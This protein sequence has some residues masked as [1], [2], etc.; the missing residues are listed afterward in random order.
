MRK[1]VI[2]PGG[3]HPFHAGHMALYTAAREAFPSAEIYVAATADTSTRPFPFDVKKKLARLAGIPAHRF[4]QVKS[5]FRANEITE[6]FEPNDTV[7][8]FVR[9]EKD[10][11]QQPQSGGVKKDG[12][13]SYL[14]PYK[15]NKL[16]PMNRHAYMDYLPVAQFGSGMTSATE[17]RSKWPGMTPEQRAALVNDMYPATVG[18]EQLTGVTVKM[19]NAV[20]TPGPVNERENNAET[21]D[22]EPD[23]RERLQRAAK[24][25]EYLKAMLSSRVHYAPYGDDEQAAFFKWVQRSLKHS[26]EDSQKQQ[27]LILN[28]QAQIKQLK[29]NMTDLHNQPAASLAQETAVGEATLVN[30]PDLGMQVRPDGGMGS[31]SEDAL[32][33]NVAGKMS[34]MLNMIRGKNYQ[35]LYHVLYKA[36][37]VQS[38]VRALAELDGF[39]SQSSDPVAAGKE[40]NLSDYVSEKRTKQPPLPTTGL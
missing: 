40:V 36:G 8:I 25:P 15:R 17:I 21:P 32:V 22:S 37:A 16:E 35:G 23:D 31:W 11:A 24:D 29:N 2:I 39:R 7:L 19:L 27:Q 20:M 13:P 6:H 3:F 28:L 14:Q 5:P 33:K 1:L 12:T 38:M 10:Q 9:S 26:E 18:N 4:I 30:D 34:E